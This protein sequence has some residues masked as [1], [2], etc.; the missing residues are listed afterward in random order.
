VEA[1]RLPGGRGAGVHELRHVLLEEGRRVHG[2][3]VDRGLDAEP[4]A[5]DA[6]AARSDFSAA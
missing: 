4:V 6:R 5:R 2:A 3:V 1:K